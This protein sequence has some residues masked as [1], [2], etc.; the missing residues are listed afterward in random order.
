MPHSLRIFK[1]LGEAGVDHGHALAVATVVASSREP[2]ASYKED[3]VVD[4]L[5]EAGV[6]EAQAEAEARLIA[7]CFPS[8]R[9]KRCFNIASIR[10][11]LVRGGLSPDLADAFIAAIEP[12]AATPR[13]STLRLPI[14]WT[15]KPGQ[16]VMC[17]FRF[18]IKP[19][20]QKE[21]RAIVVSSKAASGAG[22]CS[23]VPVSLTASRET[24]PFHFE[25]KAGRYPFFHATE[26]VWAVCDHV[27]TLALSRLWQV[28]VGRR[29]GIPSISDADLAEVRNRLGTGLGLQ[30]S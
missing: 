27:Y 19:E 1:T 22:R 4:L 12:C 9:F 30:P 20:M 23:L 28:N 15:P 2:L 14:K 21:R 13:G 6:P 5:A 26:P 29:P 10:V 17:D 8:E 16:V 11:D 7:H 18:L 24:N 3:G 25:F